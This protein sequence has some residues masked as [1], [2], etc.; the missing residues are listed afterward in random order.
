MTNSFLGIIFCLTLSSGWSVGYG[1]N[2][3]RYNIYWIG[4]FGFAWGQEHMNYKDL[5]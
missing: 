1:E 2:S 4:P 5:W 3:D